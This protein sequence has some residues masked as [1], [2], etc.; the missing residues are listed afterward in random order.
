[1]QMKSTWQEV[2]EELPGF[3]LFAIAMYLLV[4]VVLCVGPVFYGTQDNMVYM[5]AWH[6]PLK[7]IGM[8]HG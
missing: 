2:R 4:C 1:M 6:W 7:L 8:F 3:I 5:P